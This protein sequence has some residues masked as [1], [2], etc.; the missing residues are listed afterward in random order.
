MR[1]TPKKQC[2]GRVRLRTEYLKELLRTFL[3]QL[4]LL[5][6][7]LFLLLL[8]VVAVAHA[9]K[10]MFV[11]VCCNFCFDIDILDAILARE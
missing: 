1:Q 6:L 11:V 8:L 5:L 9:S 10:Q 4:L 2:T 7:L 3:L